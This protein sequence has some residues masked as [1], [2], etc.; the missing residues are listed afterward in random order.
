MPSLNAAQPRR[1][2]GH[3][4]IAPNRAKRLP[5]PDAILA[6]L[7]RGVRVVEAKTDG[8]YV[9]EVQAPRSNNPLARA[10]RA[11]SEIGVR[12]V[13]TEVHVAPDTVVQRLHLLEPDESPL[14]HRRLLLALTVLAAACQT[15]GSVPFT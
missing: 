10:F 13:H 4:Q 15:V 14:T 7:P 3:R 9:V 5:N 8:A 11:L 6:N 2:S 12:L 1:P